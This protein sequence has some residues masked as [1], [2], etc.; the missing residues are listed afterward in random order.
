MITGIHHATFITCDF[1]KSR[2]FYE[3]ILG[4]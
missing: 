1:A 3:D 2:V 4:L